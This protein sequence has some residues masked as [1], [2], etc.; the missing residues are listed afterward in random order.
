MNF[1][2][3]ERGTVTIYLVL[4]FFT[5]L[6][7]T[8]L[9]VDLARIRVAQNRL[10][11]IANASARS[12]MADYNTNLKEKFGLFAVDD[13]S[14][15]QNFRKYIEANLAVSPGQNFELFDYRYE[16]SS[17][18]LRQPVTDTDALKQQIIEDMKYAAPIEITRNLLEKFRPL[19]KLAQVFNDQNDKRESV[20]QINSKVKGI[21]EIN[22]SIKKKKEKIRKQK[23]QLKV[24]NQKIKA[25]GADNQ[26]DKDRLKAL[27]ETRASLIGQ[28][29][30]NKQGIW[31][32]L[33]ASKSQRREIEQDIAELGRQPVSLQTAGGNEQLNAYIQDNVNY[34]NKEN[35]DALKM[36][37][38]EVQKNTEQ[39]DSAVKAFISGDEDIN[40][41]L[42]SIINL[43]SADV[44]SK[45]MAE[46]SPVFDQ[47][48]ELTAQ[49]NQYR[50]KFMSNPIVR[51]YSVEA[52]VIS[53]NVN[54][55]GIDETDKNIE[56]F[57]KTL[58]TILQITN[59]ESGF[60]NM[61]DE[62]F[63]NEYALN[64]F[65]CLAEGPPKDSSGSSHTEVEYV[66]YG[67]N[68]GPQAIAELY[69]ARFALDTLAYFLFSKPPA[70][71]D[72]LLRGAYSMVMGAV[73]A[74]VD[75]YKLLAD[76]GNTVAV[77]EMVP[78]NPLKRLN[79]NLNYK[80][81]LR[82]FMA[83]HRDENGKLG[84]I[85]ELINSGSL[86]GDSGGYTL[87]DGSISISIKLWFLPLAG[88]SN[89]DNGPFDTQFRNDRCYITKRV[90]FEY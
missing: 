72:L 64:Y 89:L 73:Q 48:G 21:S 67:N 86:V 65:S 79:L 12:V 36:S 63:I 11:G 8:G 70:P 25:A 18:S 56:G 84:R 1:F 24:V 32:D 45:K 47:A 20:K 3:N 52:P 68:P 82:L 2:R 27:W 50:E 38:K 4:I 88:L 62:M 41:A 53:N 51:G 10:R 13:S 78:D 26:K 74:S 54:S 60:V 81:H 58:D 44:L 19:D 71:A 31:A 37:I 6:M 39:A 9:F 90:E 76:V 85:A 46:R 77:A 29:E 40:E 17:I 59:V 28:I 83:F 55:F 23:L 5:L 35:I 57:T 87:M 66:L 75:T 15:E 22:A 14:C 80:D 7:F 69:Q 34:L 42:F 16:G 43:D 33:E 49:L 61:R 30:K